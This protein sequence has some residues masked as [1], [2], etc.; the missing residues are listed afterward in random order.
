MYSCIYYVLNECHSVTEQITA[1]VLFLCFFLP[2]IFLSLL[3]PSSFLYLCFLCIS[4]VGLNQK[5]LTGKVTSL[6]EEE[7]RPT[8]SII[9]HVVLYGIKLYCL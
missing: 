5:G 9:L 6:R 1:A 2:A 7:Y 8:P 3:Y 4:H